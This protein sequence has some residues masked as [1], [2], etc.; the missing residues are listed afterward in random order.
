[1]VI[2]CQNKDPAIKL[3]TQLLHERLAQWL[4][5]P[6]LHKRARFLEEAYRCRGRGVGKPLADSQG[7]LLVDFHEFAELQDVLTEDL[8]A[9][10]WQ[11]AAK[12]AHGDGLGGRGDVS[13]IKRELAHCAMQGHWQEW[14]LNLLVA[15]GGQWPRR[16]QADAGYQG[17]PLCQRCLSEEES[18]EHRIWRCPCNAGKPA[19]DKTAHL[20]PETLS[21]MENCPA[22]SPVARQH[23]PRR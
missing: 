8:D 2:L 15:V 3:R 19:Y 11:R 9:L 13:Q 22:P 16:R 4:A 18:L 6:E 10:R 1:M 7:G 12:H 21:G 5:R 20:V 17:S 14:A 23:R